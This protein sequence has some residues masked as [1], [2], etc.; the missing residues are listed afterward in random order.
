MATSRSPRP[1]ARAPLLCHGC[2]SRAHCAAVTPGDPGIVGAVQPTALSDPAT[3]ERVVRVGRP[4][5]CR[6]MR[7]KSLRAA[8]LWM[9]VQ[10]PDIDPAWVPEATG[11]PIRRHRRRDC[12]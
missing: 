11:A 7:E 6:P 1:P 9:L 8:S 4:E 10:E 12:N 2:D 3:V 5:G